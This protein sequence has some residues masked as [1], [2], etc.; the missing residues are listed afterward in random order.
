[1]F[2]NWSIIK[3]ISLSEV[4]SILFNLYHKVSSGLIILS[5]KEL[6]GVFL[7]SS[8]FILFKIFVDESFI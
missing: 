7:S 5:K 1:M 3:I 6:D 2:S 8:S 4:P